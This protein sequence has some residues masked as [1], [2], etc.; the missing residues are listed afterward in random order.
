MSLFAQY[1][2]RKQFVYVF[3][4]I[5][6]KIPR[7]HS[8]SISTNETRYSFTIPTG[9][10]PEIL[11]DKI[12]VF[13]QVLSSENIEI[14]GDSKRLTLTVYRKGL[15]K[16]VKYSL[17]DWKPIVAGMSLPFIV[18]SNRHGELIAFDM[19]KN[20]HALLSGFTGLGKSS[21]LRAVLTTQMLTMKPESIRY[22]LGDL[23]RS[24]F[25]LFR[26]HSHV[27]SV[28]VEPAS[29]SLALKRV[30][31]EMQRRGNLLDKHEVT[32]FSELS[33]PL[34]WFV[35]A[36]DEVALLR[37]E[38][39]CMAIIE[40]ISSIGR[41]LGVLLILSMQRPDATILQGRLKNNL[42]VRISG[43]QSDKINAKVAGVPGA[44]L[45]KPSEKGRMIYVLDK[46]E[47][48]QAPWL[49][50]NGA[51]RLLQPFKRYDV[52]PNEEIQLANTKSVSYPAKEFT[53]GLLDEEAS[54]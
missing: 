20:P 23:K 21:L 8:V 1:K 54:Q 17:R 3:R 48:V 41:S 19:A 45:I 37:Q 43:R 44:E 7:I 29:L 51:K 49:E 53:F 11:L 39:D 22:I 12:Y 42:T 28:H 25:R 31:A 35:V 46:P 33:E 27:D 15:P 32:H 16:L 30:K 2:A 34:P 9:T 4:L 26:N 36:I 40:D 13:K 6:D 18:R 52:V 14:E 38:K 47:E 10:N 50:Y 24:E 5:T